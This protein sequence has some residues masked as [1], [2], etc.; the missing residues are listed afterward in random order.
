M[1]TAMVPVTA[2]IRGLIGHH[3]QVKGSFGNIP[4]TAR[5]QIHLGR[6]IGLHRCDSYVEK[7]AHAIRAAI[8]ASATTT[9]TTSSVVLLWS[10]NGLKPTVER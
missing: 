9:M 4:L 2:E 1:P 3:D 10:R 8:A 7:T 5:A 6:L